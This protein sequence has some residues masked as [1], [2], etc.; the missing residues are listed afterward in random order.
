[1]I[2]IDT[3][4]LLRYLLCDDEIQARKATKLI[5]GDSFVFISHVVLAETVWTLAGKKYKV[6]PND[7]YG[8]VSALFSEENV[9][10]QDQEIVW[11]ALIDFKKYRVEE[12]EKVDFPDILILHTGQDAAAQYDENFDGFYTFD[13][14]AR[15]L[16]GTMAP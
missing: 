5:T 6:S 10:F 1:M 8:A 12:N 2:S 16:P 9:L 4:V 15:C 7:I 3:N 13:A 11:R 14:A